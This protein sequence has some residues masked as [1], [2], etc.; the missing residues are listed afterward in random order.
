MQSVSYR[1]QHVPSPLGVV[2]GGLS[3]LSY[4]FACVTALSSPWRALLTLTLLGV[5]VSLPA[6]IRSLI[7]GFSMMLLMSLVLLFLPFLLPL[8]LL[9]KLLTKFGQ[10]AQ[11]WALLM[12]GVLLYTTLFY[13][14]AIMTSSSLLH[15]TTEN[16]QFA[17]TLAFI[18]GGTVMAGIGWFASRRGCDAA[19]IAIC[20]LGLPAFMLLLVLPLPHLFG[21]GDWGSHSHHH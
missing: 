19:R 16:P 1:V 3:V 15:L 12:A 2:V 14:P 17:N 9:F 18:T 4:G 20:T 11:N 6:I 5:L 10:V 21:D 13:I 8:V 7:T